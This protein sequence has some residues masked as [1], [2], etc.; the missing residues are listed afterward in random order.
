M[1]IAKAYASR[2]I[3][4]GKARKSGGTTTKDGIR[5]DIIDR[6]DRQRVDHY[7]IER[8]KPRSINGMV[9]GFSEIVQFLGG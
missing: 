5:Y 6:L 9:A 4:Q 3:K 7:E 2:L 1:I 8:A